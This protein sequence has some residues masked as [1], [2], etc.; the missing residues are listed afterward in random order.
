HL[1]RPAVDHFPLHLEDE[2][3]QQALRRGRENARRRLAT[4]QSHG[5]PD[6]RARDDPRRARAG[7]EEKDM[8]AWEQRFERTIRHRRFYRNDEAGIAMGVCAGVADFLGVDVWLVRLVT[9][10]AALF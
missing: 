8:N 5:E 6:Q 7:M 9:V 10:L 4:R 3:A 1:H 2:A